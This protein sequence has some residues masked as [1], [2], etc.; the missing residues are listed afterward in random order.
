MTSDI[1]SVVPRNSHETELDVRD[2]L[3]NGREPFSRIM[4]A[5]D[6]LPPDGVLHLRA[7]F[8]PAPLFRVLGKKGFLHEA[9]E[10][11]RED[12]SVWFWRESSTD[13][14]AAESAHDSGDTVS[15]IDPEPKTLVLDVRGLEPP[16]PMVRTLTALESMPPGHR[17]LQVNQRVPQFLLPVLTD[18]GY[19]YEIDENHPAGVVV[20]IWKLASQPNQ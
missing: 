3:R 19:G 17:L 5:V 15:G 2:D 9:R 10:N 6:A 16:E 7:T 13:A 18:R 4:S 8:E 20:R 11:G 12:W 1:P 14:A